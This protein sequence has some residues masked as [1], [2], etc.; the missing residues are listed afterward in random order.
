MSVY[1]I[2]FGIEIYVY[3]QTWLITFTCTLSPK[4]TCLP[5]CVVYVRTR[6]FLLPHK[7]W[8][9]YKITHIYS[10]I[11]VLR[12]SVAAMRRQAKDIYLVA[13][14]SQSSLHFFSPLC[15]ALPSFKGD[16]W[17]KCKQR[18]WGQ[19]MHA[20]WH[21][22][23]YTHKGTLTYPAKDLFESKTDFVWFL[24]F[25]QS[26]WENVCVERRR[27]SHKDTYV[28]DWINNLNE[29]GRCYLILNQS[30]L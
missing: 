26:V 30:G 18:W 5:V 14:N 17:E 7:Q 2:L 21:T 1:W 15:F 3:G 23:T 4:S 10:V 11:S 22:H 12:E 16:H 24:E 20:L 27:Y 25:A 29:G 9:I 8:L 19:H 13:V 6:L 28:F